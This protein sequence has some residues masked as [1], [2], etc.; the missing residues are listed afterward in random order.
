MQMFL[1]ALIGPAGSEV[2]A[3]TVWSVIETQVA[4]GGGGGGGRSG[5]RG[6]YNLSIAV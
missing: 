4:I 6:M 1:K 5:G 2:V 3:F